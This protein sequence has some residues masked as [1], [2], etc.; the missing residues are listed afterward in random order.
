[1]HWAEPAVVTPGQEPGLVGH[2]PDGD[3]FTFDCAGRVAEDAFVFSQSRVGPEGYRNHCVARVDAA[4]GTMC[5]VWIGTYGD[6]FA[7]GC[8]GRFFARKRAAA[9]AAAAVGTAGVVPAAAG[10]DAVARASHA[11]DALAECADAGAATGALD[12]IIAAVAAVPPGA[13]AGALEV[14]AREAARDWRRRHDSEWTREVALRF[15]RLLK[16]FKD[17]GSGGGGGGGGG[18]PR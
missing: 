7:P 8:W 3:G 11:I 5:G 10:G 17:G 12:A 14:H 18:A 4:L 16:V 13:A 9:P 15:G 2:V 6:A 1:M